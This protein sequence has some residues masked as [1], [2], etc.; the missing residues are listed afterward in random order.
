[1]DGQT[2]GQTRKVE[3]LVEDLV[4]RIV[5]VKKMGKQYGGMQRKHN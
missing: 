3:R 1:M 5:D 2:D 4:K